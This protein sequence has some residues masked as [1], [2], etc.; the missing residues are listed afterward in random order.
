MTGHFAPAVVFCPNVTP[1]ERPL[2]LT[3]LLDLL[4]ARGLR[5]R[6]ASLGASEVECFTCEPVEPTSRGV[7]HPVPTEEEDAL[8]RFVS[9]HAPREP[10]RDEP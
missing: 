2:T 10:S 9:R 8:A 5:L 4:A 3:A 1:G 7:R 6:S